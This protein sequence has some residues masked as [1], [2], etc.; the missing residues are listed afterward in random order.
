MVAQNGSDRLLAEILDPIKPSAL[1][2]L[3]RGT[4]KLRFIP[5]MAVDSFDSSRY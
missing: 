2:P 1:L 3:L 4:F 5:F